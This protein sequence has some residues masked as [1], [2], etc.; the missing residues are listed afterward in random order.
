MLQKIMGSQGRAEI[1]KMLFTDAHLSVHLRELAR[2]AQLSAPVLHRELHQLSELGLITQLKDGNRLNFT[3]NREHPLYNVL[4][5][6]V[7]KTDGI[8]ETM[9]AALTSDAIECAFIFGSIAK[10]TATA[11]SDVDV[12]VIGNLGL[13]DVTRMIH[14]VAEKIGR[15]INP[16]VISKDDFLKRKKEQDHFISSIIDSPKI[17]LKGTANDL[18]SMEN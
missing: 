8:E 16:Y 7:R 9:R 5:E 13:R 10:G 3:A 14:P 15:E 17:F 18:T 4:C 2:H 6:L 1:L 11:Q 12:F